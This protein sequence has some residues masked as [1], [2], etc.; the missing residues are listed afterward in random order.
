MSISGKAHKN[1]AFLLIRRSCFTIHALFTVIDKNI[2]VDFDV[3]QL[4]FEHFDFAQRSHALGPLKI[5]LHLLG[6]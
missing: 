4:E 2:F 6:K 1:L 3:F 5:V